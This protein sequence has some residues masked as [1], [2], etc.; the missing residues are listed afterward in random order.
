M[1]GLAPRRIV[2][3][4]DAVGG[5]WRYGL[6]LAA[7]LGLRGVE[8]VLAG[9]GPEP[10]EAQRCEVLRL[11]NVRLTWLDAPLDW[12]VPGPE[13]LEVQAARLADL[14]VR[15]SPDVV[16]LNVPTQAVGWRAPCPLVAVSHSC[17]VTWWDAVKTG[18]LPQAWRWQRARN[19]A[20]LD[21]ADAVVA[22]SRSHALA[23]GRCYGSVQNLFV[24]PNA[25]AA[26]ASS[27]ARAP[28]VFAAG[29]WWDEGKNAAVLDAAAALIRWPV[30]MGGACTGPDGTGIALRHARALG[31][32]PAAQVAARLARGAIVA[33][34]SLYEPFGLVSLEAAASGAALVLADIATYRELWEGAAVFADPRDP[35]ALATA[36]DALAADAPQREALGREAR[37]RAR[38][39]SVAAQAEKMLSV[40]AAAGRR[41]CAASSAA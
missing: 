4:V 11:S 41:G 27:L 31:Q 10:T 21:I 34:P 39:L 15:E 26:V 38:A 5:V 28:E 20:G 23:L 35:V 19:R 22:P 33:S 14:V 36:I 18:P 3:T 29:R 24:V 13:A 1:A 25:T 2:M 16:H 17:V 40:Y 8:V 12:L 30:A 9:L 37:A 32:L 6:D 7:T